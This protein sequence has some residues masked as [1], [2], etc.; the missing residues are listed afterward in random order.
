MCVSPN[1]GRAS[2]ITRQQNER[3]QLYN[4]SKHGMLFVS[5]AK[6][7]NPEADD[8]GPLALYARDRPAETLQ[9]SYVGLTYEPDQ[10]RV[11]ARQTLGLAHALADVILFYVL[12]EHPDTE[13]DIDG[14]LRTRESMLM[15]P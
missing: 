3:S 12:Q 6:A 2:R 14:I 4:K 1:S 5:S 11:M 8:I 9:V 7:L 10:P 13:A 15:L